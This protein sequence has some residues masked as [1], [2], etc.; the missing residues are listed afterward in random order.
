[1]DKVVVDIQYRIRLGVEPHVLRAAPTGTGCH[2]PPPTRPDHP[3]DVLK[4][5]DVRLYPD[6]QPDY[7][8]FL[9]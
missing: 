6:S 8:R 7:M 1:M 4:Y 2:H 5:S 9:Y 3:C